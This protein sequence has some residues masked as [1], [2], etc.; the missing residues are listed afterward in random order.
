MKK[1]YG[2]YVIVAT[3]STVA[4][5]MPQ[6]DHGT[7]TDVTVVPSSILLLNSL[8]LC[9][10]A[11]YLSLNSDPVSITARYWSQVI[12]LRIMP[13]AAVEA[14][15]LHVFLA[16][17]TIFSIMTRR[18]P[19]AVMTPPNTMAHIISHIVFITPAIPPVETR[20]SSSSL[21]VEM[22]VAPN[23]L[24]I[25]PL[26]MSPSPICISMSLW[27]TN[28]VATPSRVAK[29]ITGIAG[30]F[31]YIISPVSTGTISSQWDILNVELMPFT[32]AFMSLSSLPDI[33]RL[34]TAYISMVTTTVGTVVFV[35]YFMCSNKGVPTVDEAKTVVSDRGDILSP[36]YAPLIMAPAVH[37]SS[38]PLARPTPISAM[39]IVA[40][41]VHDDPVTMDIRAQSIHVVGRNIIGD[42]MCNPSFIRYGT[43][44]L[45][46]HVPLSEPI[47]MSI[48][49]AVET[50][51]ILFDIASSNPE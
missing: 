31:L 1:Q 36:K 3:P 41:V 14:T 5:V 44:P 24:V 16:A 20:L 27:S 45:I 47:S 6:V 40:T 11:L 8:G 17:D 13:D 42:I 51:E 29:N 30:I 33:S 38:K 2:R 39:P 34:A 28:D 9:P 23:T 32:Y 4:W 19:P 35:M 43:I 37:P 25:V 49:M 12:A 10:I 22:L 15:R 48:T 26:N 21:P 18:N 46:I 50:L 7:S